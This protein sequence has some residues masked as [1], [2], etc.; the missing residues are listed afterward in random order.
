VRFSCPLWWARSS[1]ILLSDIKAPI[2]IQVSQG[3][4]AYF[5]GKGLANDKQQASI[6]GAVAA[7]LHVRTVA[8][9]YG[10]CVFLTSM[11]S[12]SGGNPLGVTKSVVR[13][14]L[15]QLPAVRCH[16]DPVLFPCSCLSLP[17]RIDVTCEF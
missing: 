15:P 10:V 6:T 17:L 4:A 12:A 16:P 13:A 3:G 1:R 9:A 14:P 11:A 2:I 8:K 5:A 7:A